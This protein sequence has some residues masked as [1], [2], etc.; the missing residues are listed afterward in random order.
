MQFQDRQYQTDYLDE[1]SAN[2]QRGFRRQLM[3]APTG[4]GKGEMVGL[5]GKRVA[6]RGKRMLLMADRRRLIEQLAGRMRKFGVRWHVEMANLPDASLPGNEWVRRD[7]DAPII[8]ASRDTLLS[9]TMRNDW[10]GL[11]KVDMVALDEAHLWEKGRG[12]ELAAAV[13]APFLLG[14]T[15]TPC[16]GDGTGLG[17]DNWDVIV[18]RVTMR[19]LIEKKFLV[20]VKYFAPPELG[21]KRVAGEKTGVSGDPVKH[22]MDHAE[23]KRTVAFLEGVKQAYAVRDRF[24]AAGVT[25]E[26]IE[27]DTPHKDRQRIMDDIAAGKV[28]WCGGV[29]TL[30]T[31]VDVPEWE[32]CQLLIKCGS[33]VKYRQCGGRVMRTCPDLHGP[34]K[35]KEYAI[36]LDHSAAVMEHGFLDEPVTWEL[37][38]TDITERVKKEREADGERA[39]PVCCANCGCLFAGSPVCP[40]CGTAIPRRERKQEPDIHRE[41]LV[42]LDAPQE[43]PGQFAMRKQ[44][45]WTVFLRMCVAKGWPAKKA[46]VMFKS[47]FG[48]W[49]ENMGVTPT[50]RYGDRDKPVSDLCPNLIRKKN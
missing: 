7:P 10:M 20:P 45:E 21:K 16:Y 44:R 5:M 25:A 1:I 15:A 14:M 23:G 48:D 49:P 30:T 22:W 39:N 18:E 32:V 47:K 3:V 37:D 2:W 11:P 50:F 43:T 28:L 13:G 12:R 8:V 6:D 36:F 19:E 9:R 34:G 38:D 40:E 26:V 29:G 33:F 41:L 46:N 27:A 35:D 4:A 31:G 24:R 17:R 42:E